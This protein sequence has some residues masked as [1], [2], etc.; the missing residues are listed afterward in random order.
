MNH[1]PI[2]TAPKD[3]TMLL[4]LVQYDRENEKHGSP[5]EDNAWDRPSWTIG[6]NSLENTGKDEWQ[7]AGWNWEQDC[8]TEGRGTPIGWLPFYPEKEQ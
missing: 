4:L 8:F 3:G 1:N 7:I 2:E 5:L 6:V